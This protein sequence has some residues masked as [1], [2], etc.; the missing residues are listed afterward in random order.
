MRLIISNVEAYTARK[1][2]QK[3]PPCGGLHKKTTRAEELSTASLLHA[4][5]PALGK[6]GE[7]RVGFPLCLF[8]GGKTIWCRQSRSRRF[9]G[10][11][12]LR[13]FKYRLLSLVQAGPVDCHHTARKT[14]DTPSLDH[15]EPQGQGLLHATRTRKRTLNV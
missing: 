13:S 6:K 11:G 7:D 8:K 4:V 10:G 14:R 2:L 1:T 15:T 5:F 3:R 9:W 12:G